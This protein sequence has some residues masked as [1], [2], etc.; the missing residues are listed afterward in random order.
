[1]K[2]TMDGKQ[3]KTNTLMQE[4][5]YRGKIESI[6][7]GEQTKIGSEYL[8]TI[9][10]KIKVLSDGETQTK[11][12]KMILTDQV[13]SELSKLLHEFDHLLSKDE[14]IDIMVLIDQDC[15]VE[16]IHNISRKGNR[17]ANI[18]L[19]TS[20]TEDLKVEDNNE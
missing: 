2:I 19:I 8:N 6:K 16:I 9:V 17:F 10:F 1:M 4:G 11:E 15:E 20:L 5:K 13:G 7:E 12:K 18:G 14:N 3:L